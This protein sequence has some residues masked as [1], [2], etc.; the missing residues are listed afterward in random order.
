ML[1]EFTIYPTDQMHMSRDV[2]KMIEILEATGVDYRLG[3]MSTSVEG[4]WDQI[5]AAIRLCHEAE[6]KHHGRV[7]TTITIDD[8]RENAHH[9]D[10]MV[11]AVERHL[12][13]RAKRATEKERILVR[14][15]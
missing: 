15:F 8:R 3:P 2:A 6:T 13:H 12:K 9:L 11:E 5:T 7:I 10:E 14:D 4:T 1:A